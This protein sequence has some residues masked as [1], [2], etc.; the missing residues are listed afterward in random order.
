[1]GLYAKIAY[2]CFNALSSDKKQLHSLP[3][4]AI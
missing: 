4:E 3:N 1:M 2:F